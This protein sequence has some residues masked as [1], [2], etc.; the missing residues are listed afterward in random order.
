[1]RE[2]INDLASAEPR[3]GEL[4]DGMHSKYAQGGQAAGGATFA[5]ATGVGEQ[6]GREMFLVVWD[7]I[8]SALSVVF[9]TTEDEKVL[10]KTIE[11]LHQFAKI[12]CFHRSVRARPYVDLSTV[13][14]T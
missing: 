13:C 9:E 3:W 4:L 5:P 1:M 10:R 2:D 12:C 11:G 8:I 6:T 7:R 14:T